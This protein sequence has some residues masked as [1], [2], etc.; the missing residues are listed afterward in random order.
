MSVPKS[1]YMLKIC[2]PIAPSCW[3]PASVY[4]S[5]SLGG[6]SKPVCRKSM[7]N[8]SGEPSLEILPFLMLDNWASQVELV[9]KNPPANAGDIRDAGLIP[10]LGRSPGGGHGYPLHYSCLE[11]PM[12][13][14]AW[15]ATVHRVA[16]S[17]TQLKW[18][19]TAH[20]M[21]D[22]WQNASHIKNH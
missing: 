6:Y 12:D 1:I 17:W 5:S 7:N 16:K 4:G 13:R 10:C 9:A 22:D 3:C 2:P 8:E 11:N 20:P 21:Q 19:N 14:G 18:L 15:Q